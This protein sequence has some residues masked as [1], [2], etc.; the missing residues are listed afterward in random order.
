MK[1]YQVFISYRRDGG[2]D[3]AGRIADRLAAR[4][5]NVFFDLESMR[6]GK[7]NEQIY[8]AIDRCTDVLVILP[9]DSLDR[10]ADPDDWVRLEISYALR[11]GKTVIPVMMR[12]F[13]FPKT[14][15]QD[16]DALR[17]MQG[18]EASV[19]FFDSVLDRICDL[20]KS[21]PAP[22]EQAPAAKREK[23]KNKRVYLI[24]AAAVAALL[25]G[26]LIFF[27]AK[28]GSGKKTY[29]LN[30]N[31]M[32]FHKPDCPSAEQTLPKNKKTY[33]G[34]RASCI[35][36]GYKPCSVCEP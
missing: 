36:K 6:S 34:T 12:G 21:D 29:I 1:D 2:A 31:T 26:A 30:T 33:S 18:V 14:L 24:A 8:D 25:A 17:T 10:C 20:M 27:M 35:E 28:G 16:I 3:L 9:P 11:K 15:P 19:S 22:T 23:K 5:Y 32:V 7:F 4:G 13:A